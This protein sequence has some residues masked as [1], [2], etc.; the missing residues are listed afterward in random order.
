MK[1]LGNLA[2]VANNHPDCMLQIYNGK[3]TIHTGAGNERKSFSFD[4]M[5]DNCVNEMIAYLNFGTPI[6]NI[7]I[8]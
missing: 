6:K 5:D 4:A 3:A 7:N 2:I 8:K 1:Q